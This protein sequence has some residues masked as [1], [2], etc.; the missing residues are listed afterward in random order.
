MIDVLTKRHS[1]YLSQP[2]KDEWLKDLYHATLSL[3]LETSIISISDFYQR[4]KSGDTFKNILHIKTKSSVILLFSVHSFEFLTHVP[5]QYVNSARIEVKLNM[6][7]LEICYNFFV[8]P[9]SLSDRS[10]S[11]CLP[12]TLSLSLSHIQMN[13]HNTQTQ[14]QTIYTLFRCEIFHSVFIFALLLHASLILC[15]MLLTPKRITL[16]AQTFIRKV[17]GVAA[18]AD[19]FIS[20]AHVPN[21][22]VTRRQMSHDVINGVICCATKHFCQP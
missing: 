8:K 14:T 17:R 3:T 1:L 2:R 9:L 21:D 22:C 20:R 10:L 6:Y 12:F 19:I 7:S 4:V 5:L 11:L 16:F 15:S 18:K 13:T